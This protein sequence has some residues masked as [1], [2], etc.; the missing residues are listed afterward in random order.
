MEGQDPDT[1]GAIDQ[2][3]MTSTALANKSLRRGDWP[4]APVPNQGG[5]RCFKCGS[6]YHLRATCPVDAL[7]NRAGRKPLDNRQ[8]T[9]DVQA[10]RAKANKKQ[11][12]GRAGASSGGRGGSLAGTRNAVKRRVNAIEAD[13]AAM[14]GNTD[15]GSQFIA[16]MSHPS[17]AGGFDGGVQAGHNKQ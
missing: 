9:E 15:G 1:V 10:I 6:E 4:G 17:P 13:E 16:S 8:A 12:G 3:T 11:R 2:R 7:S 5:K 14:G